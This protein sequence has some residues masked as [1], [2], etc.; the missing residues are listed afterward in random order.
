M[1]MGSDVNS[2]IGKQLTSDG[3][4]KKKPNTIQHDE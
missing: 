3:K 4:Y 1:L 2:H